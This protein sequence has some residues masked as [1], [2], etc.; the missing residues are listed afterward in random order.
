[1]TKKLLLSTA[2]LAMIAALPARAE[3]QQGGQ[4]SFAP[5]QTAPYKGIAPTSGTPGKSAAQPAGTATI[6]ES[7]AGGM[8]PL[9]LGLGLLGIAAAAAAAGGGGSSGSSSSTPTVTPITG[10]GSVASFSTPEYYASGG[11]AQTDAA[12]RY[13]QGAYG[14]GVL[15]SAYDTGA[16]ATNTDLGANIDLALSYNYFAQSR[17]LND[18]IGH[19]THVAGILVGVQNSVGI[20]GIAWGAKLMMLQGIGTSPAPAGSY[21]DGINR[22]VAAG[23]VAMNNSWSYVDQND[24]SV[25][26][27]QF[28]SASQIKSYIGA[29]VITALDNA[30]AAGM[31]SVFAAGN[32]SAAN[33]S[34]MAGLPEYFSEL[35]GSILGVVAVD[36][37]HQIASFS[38]RCGEAMNYCIAAPGVNILSTYPTTMGSY[39]TMSGTSMAAPYVTGAIGVLKSEFPELTGQQIVQILEQSAT[40][41]GAP[42][43]DPIYGWGE[44]NLQNAVAAA[45]ALTV[46][47]TS[48]L[49]AGA[50][51]ANQSVIQASSGVAGALRGALASQTMIVTDAYD[52]GYHVSAA[53]FVSTQ[54]NVTAATRR[55]TAFAFGTGGGELRARSASS[56]ISMSLY[57]SRAISGTGWVDGT[58]IEAPYLVGLESASSF[59]YSGA[60]G[61]GLSMSIDQAFGSGE[62][63]TSDARYVAASLAADFGKTSLSVSV[64][65]RNDEGGFLGTTIGGAFGTGMTSRTNFMSVSA[66]LALDSRTDLQV[67]AA[68]GTTD[69]TSSGLLSSGQNLHSTALAIG[70]S[71]RGL[72]TAGDRI[73]IGLSRPVTLQSGSMTVT[74]PTAVGAAVGNVRS[75]SVTMAT[76]QIE[77][78]PQSAPQDL[79]IGYSVPV[80]NG[81]LS[82]GVLWQQGDS[83]FAVAS[84]GW[85][86][87]F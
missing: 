58:A 85:N 10:G 34:V 63:G 1:M 67:T 6:V 77:V 36:S 3:V 9:G 40:D 46:Q 35:N 26:I 30:A 81:T 38:N 84:V 83:H 12:Y 60:L 79:Q 73:T 80:A 33:P 75:S 56:S 22:S 44:L 14:Q 54:G 45:G 65:T 29:S 32:D 7:G 68:A 41:L 78:Q 31:V 55:A 19:G 70:L 43:V 51:S 76:T 16:D 57:D 15:L 47:T 48:T 59:S 20:E 62:A 23:A 2:A 13:A 82:A 50:V 61:G 86:I 49:N 69:F 71:H 39:A 52:R 64:G 24:K 28:T 42:G 5:A 21:T 4:L 87:S 8:S 11:L 17:A 74:L 27:D 53:S 72:L 37:N 66:R 18:T 25:T